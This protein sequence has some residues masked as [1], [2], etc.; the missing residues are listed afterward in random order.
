[1]K[2]HQ[3]VC[4]AFHGPKPFSRA[5]VIHKDENSLNNKPSNLTWG[6]QKENLNCPGF[7]AYCRSDARKR[8]IARTRQGVTLSDEISTAA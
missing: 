7:L 4:E 8:Q 5:V 1:M 6:T 3:L 2:V